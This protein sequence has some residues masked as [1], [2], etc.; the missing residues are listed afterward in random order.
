MAQLLSTLGSNLCIPQTFLST[1]PAYAPNPHCSK[2]PYAQTP[3]APTLPNLR[4]SSCSKP[5]QSPNLI[6][7]KSLHV[8]YLLMLQIFKRSKKTNLIMLQSPHALGTYLCSNLPIP[9]T[10]YASNL[11]KSLHVPYLLTHEPHHAP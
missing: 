11:P 9:Q 3:L 4:N 1:K 8:P 2:L 7:P 10:S 6:M 5:E